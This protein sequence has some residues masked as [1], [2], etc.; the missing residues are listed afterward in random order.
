LY[1]LFYNQILLNSKIKPSQ[2][3]KIK[4]VVITAAGRGARLFPLTKETPKEM[5]PIYVKSSKNAKPVLKP[6]LHVIFDSVYDTG[7]RDFCFIVGRGKRSI[8]DHFLIS[9]NEKQETRKNPE[10]KNYFTKLHNSHF[11]YVQ[12][13]YPK[14]FGDAVLKARSFVNN[15]N[16]LLHAG[17]DAILSNK[18]DHLQR[19][20]K[21]FLKHDAEAAILVKRIPDPRAYGVI[22]GTEISKKIFKVTNFEEKPKKP[23]SNL[24]S[25]G[26][27]LFKPLIF[28]VLKKVKPDKNGEIQ[29]ADALK[30]LIKSEFTTIAVELNDN[31]KRVDVGTPESYVNC[32]RESYEFFN[33]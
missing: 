25:I 8:E 13:P 5:I 2:L 17:D 23:K 27:Y 1:F 6:I 15:D 29:L 12:Q 16:F 33:K 28:E 24:A 7:I 14:G 30:N 22:E 31:E 26:I 3:A 9:E 19:L 11:T 32:I 21:A 4:K 10:V 20:E 18:N